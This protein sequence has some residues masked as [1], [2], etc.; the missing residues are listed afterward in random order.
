MGRGEEAARPFAH[1]TAAPPPNYI[2]A[3]GRVAIDVPRVTRSEGKLLPRESSAE[4][5]PKTGEGRR[6]R[7][8]LGSRPV[9]RQTCPLF[10]GWGRGG[11]VAR[12]PPH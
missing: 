7:A 12:A 10:P 5:G 6:G 11:A 4:A 9:C 1:P 8:R 3:A 2:K